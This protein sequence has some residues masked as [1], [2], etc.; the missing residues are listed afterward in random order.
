VELE[1]AARNK[2]NHN[3]ADHG[4]SASNI[5]ADIPRMQQRKEAIVNALNQQIEKS[6]P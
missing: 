2:L 3:I 5:Q 6:L 4:I 1:P